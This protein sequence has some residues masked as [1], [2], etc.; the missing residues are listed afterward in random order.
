M[1][2]RSYVIADHRSPPRTS[3]I[4]LH[5]LPVFH[6][7]SS[8][9][10]QAW[11]FISWHTAANRR[12][13]PSTLRSYLNEHDELCLF[14]AVRRTKVGAEASIPRAPLPPRVVLRPCAKLQKQQGSARPLMVAL[15]PW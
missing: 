1:R 5:M 2:V 11:F 3:V 9:E 8:V 6:E 15:R 10:Y 14:R 7:V 4:V 13:Q 12:G